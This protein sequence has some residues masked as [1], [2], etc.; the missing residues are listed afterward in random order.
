MT[1]DDAERA[2]FGPFTIYAPDGTEFTLRRILHATATEHVFDQSRLQLEVWGPGPDNP[3]V[4]IAKAEGSIVVDD[5][6]S[7][8]LTNAPS[9]R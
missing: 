3:H 8:P 7:A 5:A 2:V 9:W 1:S 6:I 4:W